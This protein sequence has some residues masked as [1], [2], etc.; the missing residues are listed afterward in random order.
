MRVALYARVSTDER[1]ID[2]QRDLL[3][4]ALQGAGLAVSQFHG[5]RDEWEHQ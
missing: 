5:R 2:Q 4:Q 3:V 1:N